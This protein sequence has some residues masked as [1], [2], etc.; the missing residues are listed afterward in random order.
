MFPDVLSPFIIFLIPRTSRRAASAAVKA[1][2]EDGEASQEPDHIQV[3]PECRSRG[4][5]TAAAYHSQVVFTFFFRKVN[6]VS[7]L[8]DPN[9]NIYS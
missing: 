6:S 3:Q 5:Y 1:A 4:V 7:V 2:T 9:V 8:V